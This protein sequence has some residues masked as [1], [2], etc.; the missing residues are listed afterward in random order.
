[1]IIAGCNTMLQKQTHRAQ[2]PHIPG[3]GSWYVAHSK[4]DMT[5]QLLRDK[6][7]YFTNI[8]CQGAYQLKYSRAKIPVDL[9]SFSHVI[10]IHAHTLTYTHV[11]THTHTHSIWNTRTSSY[12]P[13]AHS[14]THAGIDEG[15]QL[16]CMKP[17]SEAI[18]TS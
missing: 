18:L 6:M 8:E 7:A 14:F 3:S 15:F 4:Q 13:W 17:T 9:V 1:M 12:T 16:H 11:R 10:C 5:Q 2:T